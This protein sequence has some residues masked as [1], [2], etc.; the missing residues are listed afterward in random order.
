MLLDIAMQVIKFLLK[1]MQ[2]NLINLMEFQNKQEA[3]KMSSSI[4]GQIVY[5]FQPNF[6]C[7][8][9]EAITEKITKVLT[10]LKCGKLIYFLINLF[11]NF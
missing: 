7:G 8:I 6:T 11:T 5:R 3:F 10:N 2:N 1:N 4:F 9:L